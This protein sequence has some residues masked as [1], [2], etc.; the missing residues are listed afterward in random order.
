MLGGADAADATAEA[1]IELEMPAFKMR[2]IEGD[3]GGALTA[4]MG[5]IRD[6]SLETSATIDCI[7]SLESVLPDMTIIRLPLVSGE[8]VCHNQRFAITLTT[9]Q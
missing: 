4:H 9:P 7:S 8:R 5:E 6:G 2:P 3:R 1:S